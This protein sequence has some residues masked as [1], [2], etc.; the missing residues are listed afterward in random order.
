MT[1]KQS[2]TRSI[3][4]LAL[5]V[6]TGLLLLHPAYASDVKYSYAKL[7]YV[8]QDPGDLGGDGVDVDH[9]T[10]FEAGGSF[11]INQNLFIFADLKKATSEVRASNKKVHGSAD[12]DLQELG[13][14]LGYIHPLNNDWDVNAAVSFIKLDVDRV[15]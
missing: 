4:E 1:R 14:G 10:G 3:T 7:R 9:F 5:I 12:F 6:L 15:L 13:G 11:Q 8:D 2:A